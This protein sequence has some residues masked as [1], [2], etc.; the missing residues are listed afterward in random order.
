VV[1]VDIAPADWR[2]AGSGVMGRVSAGTEAVRA[3][4][5]VFGLGGRRPT[6]NTTMFARSQNVRAS[7][8]DSQG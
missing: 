4:A 8:L 1:G 2:I 6:V 5:W 3:M 7:R